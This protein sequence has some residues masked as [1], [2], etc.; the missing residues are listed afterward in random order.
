MDQ[1]EIDVQEVGLA[2]FAADEVLVPNFLTQSSRCVTH[3]S[4]AIAKGRLCGLTGVVDD[5]DPV[6]AAQV[7]EV[8]DDGVVLGAAVIPQGDRV[9]LPSEPHVVLGAFDSIE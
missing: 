8:V 4:N 7:R 2:L 9:G 6:E 1:V 3:D 5:G